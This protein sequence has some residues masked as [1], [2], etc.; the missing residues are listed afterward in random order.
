MLK[1][2]QWSDVRF[3]IILCA[4]T[5]F[6]L[7]VDTELPVSKY[8]QKHVS[9]QINFFEYLPIWSKIFDPYVEIQK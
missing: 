1:E 9:K 8:T 7:I 2:A 3:N 6:L 5:T 4:I